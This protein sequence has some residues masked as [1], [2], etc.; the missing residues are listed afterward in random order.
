MSTKK[1]RRTNNVKKVNNVFVGTV[2]AHSE[3]GAT[4]FTIDWKINKFLS[5]ILKKDEIT[6]KP[7]HDDVTSRKWQLAITKKENGLLTPWLVLKEPED[8]EHFFFNYYFSFIDVENKAYLEYDNFWY[9]EKSHDEWG[10]TDLIKLQ[11]LVD[12]K[13]SWVPNSV[14]HFRCVIQEFPHDLSLPHA[15]VIE[16][17]LFMDETFSDITFRV[18]NKEFKAHQIIVSNRAPILLQKFRKSVYAK[19]SIDIDLFDADAFQELLRYIYTDEVK[20][21]DDTHGEETAKQLLSIADT[22]QLPR[23]KKM[24][25][26][27]LIT[28]L[29]E[30][31]ALEYFLLAEKNGAQTLKALCIDVIVFKFSVIEN[32]EKWIHFRNTNKDLVDVIIKSKA[33]HE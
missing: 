16:N 22:L 24:C 30:D 21:T 26:L 3:S 9:L 1:R 4:K 10:V 23:L 33:K 32:T 25:E 19:N 31:N 13:D 17:T 27:S 29:F 11:K 6:S 20:F 28:E 18:Q 2:N 8:V 7:L 14:L 15:A 12:N 5:L